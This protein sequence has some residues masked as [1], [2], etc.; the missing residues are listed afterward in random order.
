M[1]LED[2]AMTLLTLKE[3][4]NLLGVETSPLGPEDDKFL[5][6]S[7]TDLVKE[8]DKQWIRDNSGRLVRELKYMKDTFM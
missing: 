1:S 2:Q 7:T 5:I 8:H 6:E 4:L 3:C